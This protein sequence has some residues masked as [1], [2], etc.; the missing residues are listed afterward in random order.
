MSNQTSTAKGRIVA[1]GGLEGY[2]ALVTGGG[3]GIGKACAQRLAVD[4]A[5]VT[6]CGRTESSLHAAAA[7]IAAAAAASGC[8]GSVR[9]V[10]GDVTNEDD[11]AR[12][13]ATALE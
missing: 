5:A 12:F 9:T 10:G 4:G 3:T 11:V 2:A 7:E 8:G 6:I 13:V 1:P